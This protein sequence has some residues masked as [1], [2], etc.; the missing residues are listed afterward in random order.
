MCN[1]IYLTSCWTIQIF[2]NKNN[3]AKNIFGHKL[4]FGFPILHGMILGITESRIRTHLKF[5]IWSFQIVRI[6]TITSI[7]AHHETSLTALNIIMFHL[8]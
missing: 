2:N 7:S 8:Y 3:T 6:V 1:L 4:L 5:L